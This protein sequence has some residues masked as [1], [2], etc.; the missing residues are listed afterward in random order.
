MTSRKLTIVSNRVMP[1][2]LKKEASRNI[3]YRYFMIAVGELKKKIS[4]YPARV[5]HSQK[6]RKTSRI[7]SRKTATI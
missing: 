7:S 4:M 3:W 6:I 2:C 1:V 5:I